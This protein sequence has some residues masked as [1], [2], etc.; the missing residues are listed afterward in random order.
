MQ[1]MQSAERDRKRLVA[2][3]DELNQSAVRRLKETLGAELAT[4]VGDLPA[5]K[6]HPQMQFQIGG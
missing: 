1:A 3:R 5:K 6:K 2:D 4:K